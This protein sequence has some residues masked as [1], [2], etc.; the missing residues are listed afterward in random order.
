MDYQT[1]Q[2]IERALPLI[3]GWTQLKDPKQGGARIRVQSLQRR[4][5]IRANATR[6]EVKNGYR[7]VSGSPGSVPEDDWESLI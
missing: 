5:W 6:E 7:I 4:W 3:E 2:N 1:A